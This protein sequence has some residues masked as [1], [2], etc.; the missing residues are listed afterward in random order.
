MFQVLFVFVI[1]C[2]IFCKN[3]FNFLFFYGFTYDNKNKE[4]WVLTP[5]NYTKE[6]MKR[7]NAWNIRCLVDESFDLLFLLLT[8]YYVG[9]ITFFLWI[10][11]VVWTILWQVS[12]TLRKIL[13]QKSK[14]SS[15][16]AEYCID[17]L[18][19][20]DVTRAIWQYLVELF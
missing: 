19:Y 4:F 6:I 1:S 13:K 12:I 11:L 7:N 3:C 14:H 10:A 8:I 17:W 16:P 2:K 9:L 20:I 18:H 15:K 5:R